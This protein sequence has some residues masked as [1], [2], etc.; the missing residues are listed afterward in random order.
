MPFY[1]WNITVTADKKE[2]EPLT[3]WLKLTRGIITRIDIKFPA[4]CHGL[5]KVRL[6]QES[7]QLIP[8]SEDEWVTGDGELIPTETYAELTDKPYQLKFV[9]CSPTTIHSHVITVRIQ[10]TPFSANMMS[11]LKQIADELGIGEEGETV[12]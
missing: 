11:L 6:F 10:V 9:A 7:L 3:K 1:C 5:V 12:E 8:L 2:D 4:G